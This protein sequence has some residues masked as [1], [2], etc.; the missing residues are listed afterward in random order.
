MDQTQILLEIKSL[1]KQTKS[2]KGDIGKRWEPN[3]RSFEL[4]L[5]LK[6]RIKFKLNLALLN[7]LFT[8]MF[9]VLQT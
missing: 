7:I 9:Q 1:S 3:S 8:P 6:I 2:D 4:L 5:K